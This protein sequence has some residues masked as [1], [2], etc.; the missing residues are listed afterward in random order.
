[1]RLLLF[2]DLPTLT[3]ADTRNYRKFHKF[4]IT[5]G[6]IMSQYSVYTKLVLNATQADSVKELLKKNVP[7]KGLVQCLQITER[8]FASIEY[9]AGKAQ[10]KIVD[11]DSRWVEIN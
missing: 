8:Q 5:N 1:M 6:F 9:M 2:F 10:T 3:V 4:L 7:Q 11:S